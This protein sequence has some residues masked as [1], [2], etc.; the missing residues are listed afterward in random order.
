MKSISLILMTLLGIVHCL[1]KRNPPFTNF[2]PPPSKE[3]TVR[4]L[5]VFQLG[6]WVEN[7]YV[8]PNGQILATIY[9]PFSGV[10]ETH[11][12][13]KQATLAAIIPG[14][15]NVLGIAE[16]RTP[17]T[18]YV[19]GED[20]PVTT[21]KGVKGSN[22]IYQVDLREFDTSGG[23]QRADVKIALK[24]PNG[25]A[26]NGLAPVNAAK[27]LYVSTDFDAGSIYLL[28]IVTGETSVI[29]SNEWTAH[30]PGSAGGADGIKVRDGYIYWT[31]F[32]ANVFARVPID[33]AGMPTGAPEKLADVFSDDFC[34]GWSDEVHLT[35]P[36]QSAIGVWRPG[37]QSVQPLPGRVSGPTAVQLGVD[38][39]SLIVT[40]SGNDT[41][42]PNNITRP[43]KVV[44]I[45][46]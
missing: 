39:R 4:D 40:T 15:A 2:P 31:S 24:V 11:K 7:L 28:N 12:S 36:E 13:S 29:I 33:E 14:I 19:I 3:G 46:L 32:S 21:L 23:L 41:Q 27:G 25:T 6:T 38:G 10:Y 44:E 18:V 45:R 16:G 22:S 34:F 20:F 9:T 37:Q 26:L 42:Y 43:G 30:L 1:P 8:R 5:Q 17:E 35:M